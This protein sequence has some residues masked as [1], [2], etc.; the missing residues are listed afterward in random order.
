MFEFCCLIGEGQGCRAGEGRGAQ[1]CLAGWLAK[2]E[3]KG[4]GLALRLGWGVGLAR[5]DSSSVGARKGCVSLPIARQ[6]LFL[7]FE[8]LLQE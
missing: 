5:S 2:A 7:V 1:L 3:G 6:L 4:G 8:R